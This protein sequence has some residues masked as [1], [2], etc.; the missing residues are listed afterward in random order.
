[1]AVSALTALG[2]QDGARDV[3]RIVLQRAEKV[4]ALDQS[5]GHAMGESAF[6]LAALGE[7]ERARAQIERALLLEPD[8]SQMAYNFACALSVYLKD[9]EGALDLLGPLFSTVRGAEFLAHARLDPDFDPIRDDRRFLAMLAEA[10]ARLAGD[11]A[12]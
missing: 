3:A 1:M 9:A 4:L 10:E 12:T 7:R 6:A 5:N 11:A 2:D 8:N